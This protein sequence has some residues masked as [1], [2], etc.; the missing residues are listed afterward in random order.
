M[1]NSIINDSEDIYELNIMIDTDIDNKYTPLNVNM[2]VISDKDKNTSIKRNLNSIPY[3]TY[4]YKY[5]IAYLKKI[6]NYNDRVNIFF[7]KQDFLRVM[8]KFGISVNSFNDEKDKNN[9]MDENI[10]IMLEIIFPTKFPVV[11]NIHTSMNYINNIPSTKPLTYNFATRF[12]YLNI[13]NKEYTVNKVILYNDIINHPLYYNLITETI[14]LQNWANKN[15]YNSL[16]QEYV[17]NNENEQLPIQYVDYEKIFMLKYRF[18]NRIINN[19]SFQ[20]LI[21]YNKAN[22]KYNANMFHRFILYLYNNF[23]QKIKISKKFTFKEVELF[24]KIIYTPGAITDVKLKQIV[25][26]KEIYVRLLLHPEK[27]NDDNLKTYKCN[28]YGEELGKQL[29]QMINGISFS[30]H[31]VKDFS[32]TDNTDSTTNNSN[33]NISSNSENVY[34]NNINTINNYFTNIV[35]FLENKDKDIKKQLSDFLKNIYNSSTNILNINEYHILSTISFDYQSIISNIIKHKYLPKHQTINNNM[36]NIIFELKDIF[37]N[38]HQFKIN[39][40]TTVVSQ[41][42]K[43]I[44]DLNYEIDNNNNILKDMKYKQSSDVYKT[45]QVYNYIKNV[46]KMYVY[47]LK[48]IYEYLKY[49]YPD[50]NNLQNMGGAKKIKKTRKTSRNNKTKK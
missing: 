31:F 20:E 37:H 15:G 6:I 47:I 2:L 8:T 18:P 17:D 1:N 29:Q 44:N 32:N 19:T 4:K 28:Y 11:N 30:S 41:I 23:F 9:T 26:T 49:I 27:L 34:I 50:M 3:F 16:L 33:S 43:T 42:I 35:N 14:N 24:D 40:K 5:P 10:K 22:S 48:F 25:P 21:Q 38:Q 7:N 13:N 39:K 45:E 12:S 46:L 36:G